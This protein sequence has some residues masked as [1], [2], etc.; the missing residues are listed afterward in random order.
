MA[1]MGE[2][3]EELGMCLALNLAVIWFIIT[4]FFWGWLLL[5]LVAALWCEWDMGWPSRHLACRLCSRFATSQ[6]P[7]CCDLVGNFWRR[8]WQTF[9]SSR[10]F[11]ID[12]A[13]YRIS[14]WACFLPPQLVTSFR[15]TWDMGWLTRHVACRLCKLFAAWYSDLVWVFWHRLWQTCFSTGNF[16]RNFACYRISYWG[17]FLPAAAGH[18]S[19]VRL[20][21]GLADSAPGMS[22]VQP[23]RTLQQSWCGDFMWKMQP[24]MLCLAA[25]GNA[26]CPGVRP[27]ILQ[28]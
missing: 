14:H 15:C 20:G 24:C 1:L 19:P 26:F 8:P 12:F 13:C 22:T 4:V 3:T 10:N 6:Q 21:H 5:W 7:W 11:L 28:T 16:L 18:C 2:G 17:C 23:S 25:V 9:F 27:V